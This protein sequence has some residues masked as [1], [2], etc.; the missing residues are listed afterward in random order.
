M[1]LIHIDLQDGFT[2]DT[3]IVRVNGSEVFS[4]ANV[5][6]RFQ[7]GVATSFEVDV[8]AGMVAIQVALPLKN[9][10]E[11]FEL[12]VARTT[13]VGISTTAEGRVD[14]RLSEEPF[15]YM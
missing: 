15:T 4:K 11:S 2:N 3:V 6:T 9:V 12:Q 8:A 13:Y 5:K 1:P 10:S 14:Y 7:I